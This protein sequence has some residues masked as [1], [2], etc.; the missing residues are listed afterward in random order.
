MRRYD[1]S[2]LCWRW[3]SWPIAGSQSKHLWP[4][5][6]LRGYFKMNSRIIEP[7][8]AVP[9]L[10]VAALLGSSG[11][12]SAD[13]LVVLPN[14]SSTIVLTVDQQA[15]EQN[16]SEQ[17]FANTTY[18]QTSGAGATASGSAS[19]IPSP[20]I[21]VSASIQNGGNQAIAYQSFSYYFA[22][23]SSVDTTVPVIFTATGMVSPSSTTANVADLEVNSVPGGS[24]LFLTSACQSA[25][26][27]CASRINQPSFAIAQQI[28]VSTNVAYEVQEDVYALA[29]SSYQTSSTSTIDPVISFAPGVD[30]TGLTFEFSENVGN[31]AAVPEPSTWAMMLLGFAG[32][33]FMAYRR[34]SKPALMA[35]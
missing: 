5:F 10:I 23:S 18:S 13:T 14:A 9:A 19:I 29:Q 33:G 1:A 28:M 17:L 30:T 2:R 22:V 3:P 8:R 35:A 24:L 11:I 20:A 4:P 26:G 31:V 34:K 6:P 32:I 12:A 21:S 27:G 7:S 15:T 25:P 16:L